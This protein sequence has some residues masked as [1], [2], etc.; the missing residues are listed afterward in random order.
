MRTITIYWDTIESRFRDASG[1]F[2]KSWQ[3]PYLL[4]NENVLLQITYVVD[5][6]L[7]PSPVVATGVTFTAV[8]DNDYLHNNSPLIVPTDINKA[9]DWAGGGTADPALGQFSMRLNAAS[10]ALITAIGLLPELTNTR[11]EIDGW[12]DGDNALVF[13]RRFPLGVLNLMDRSAI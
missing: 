1:V 3:Y 13:T 9:G 6:I 4:V 2:I 7:T 5:S 10:A 8:L 11:L 12:D